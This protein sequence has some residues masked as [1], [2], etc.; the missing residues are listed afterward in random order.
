MKYQCIFIFFSTELDEAAVKPIWECIEKIFPGKPWFVHSTAGNVA[1]C[2]ITSE[3]SV[4]VTVFEN[5]STQFKL[6][7]YSMK[8]RNAEEIAEDII[9]ECEMNPWVKAVEF[10]RTINSE[11]LKDWLSFSRYSNICSEF[12][13]MKGA[14]PLKYIKKV[15]M[16][17][18]K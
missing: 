7:Q 3:M 12:A 9:K 16:K 1:D 18:K 14:R 2:E 11:S 5:E 15:N 17:S 6:L 8:D 10:Y 4:S 13:V